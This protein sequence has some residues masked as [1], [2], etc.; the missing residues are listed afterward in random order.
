MKIDLKNTDFKYLYELCDKTFSKGSG[1]GDEIRRIIVEELK[2]QY[3][4]AFVK[5]QNEKQE[6]NQGERVLFRW[7]LKDD[8]KEGKIYKITRL[9]NG[10]YK[11]TISYKEYAQDHH[12]DNGDE[13]DNNGLIPL[14]TGYTNPMTKK[15][16]KKFI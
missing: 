16:I 9:S 13:I 11:Y 2:P 1:Y 4:K 6:F 15:N 7:S 10:Q 12:Y 8:W 14:V 3:N 5:Y